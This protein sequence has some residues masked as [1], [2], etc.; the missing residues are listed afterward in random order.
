MRASTKTG[1][2]ISPFMYP[3][4]GPFVPLSEAHFLT[5]T[6]EMSVYFGLPKLASRDLER[7][8][9]GKE[10]TGHNGC[11]KRTRGSQGWVRES[12]YI[13]ISKATLL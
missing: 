13:L 8:I 12:S 6:P 3:L 11:K 2:M 10:G 7:K 9:G 1:H 5:V 4:Q